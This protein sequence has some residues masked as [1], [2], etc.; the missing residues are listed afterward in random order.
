M[1][2]LIIRLT[3]LWLVLFSQ[4]VSKKIARS[5]HKHYLKNVF[6]FVASHSK[7]H[8]Y[9]S[10]PLNTFYVTLVRHIYLHFYQ[11]V[12]NS[13][14]NQH[15]PILFFSGKFVH[16]ECHSTAEWCIQTAFNFDIG[17]RMLVTGFSL[18]ISIICEDVLGIHHTVQCF[19]WIS[20]NIWMCWVNMKY[21]I[22]YM[23]CDASNEYQICCQMSRPNYQSLLA[24]NIQIFTTKLAAW[25]S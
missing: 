9:T 21:E 16:T 13:W 5:Y 17:I 15:K 2:R 22:W 11:T 6:H 8:S 14:W 4:I 19:K 25:L 12:V 24:I 7:C 10:K 3:L 20:I 18:E 23:K 1:T